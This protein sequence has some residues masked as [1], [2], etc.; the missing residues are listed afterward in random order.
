MNRLKPALVAVC[1][2]AALY[3]PARMPR[4]ATASAAAEANDDQSQLPTLKPSNIL[5]EVKRRK[6]LEPRLSASALA[7]YANELLKQKGFDYDFDVCEIFPREMLA[8][9]TPGGATGALHTFDRPLTRL[10][11]R[12]VTFRFVADDYGSPCSECFLHVPALRVTKD[13]MEL[14]AGGVTYTLKRPAA[15]ALDEAQLVGSDLKTVQRTWQIPFQT[16]PAGVSPDG[17]SLYLDFYEDTGLDE[18]VLEVSDEGRPRFRVRREVVSAEGESVE[19]H[20]TDLLN[21]YLSFM[22]FRSGGRTHVVRFSG[23]CT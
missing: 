12:G 10:D 19:E 15:F 2:A 1:V 14:V 11:G 3:A 7:R 20:P 23:P 22:R 8:G 21:A 16:I 18:L 17:R 13:E 5:E 4:G 6:S 9:G